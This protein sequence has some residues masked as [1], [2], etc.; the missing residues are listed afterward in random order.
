MATFSVQGPFEIQTTKM[1]VGRQV[2]SIDAAAFWEI[3]SVLAKGC[4]CYVFVFK[5]AKGYKPVY[6]GKAAVPQA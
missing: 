5:A 2:T 3:Y 6:V 4:G 1:K